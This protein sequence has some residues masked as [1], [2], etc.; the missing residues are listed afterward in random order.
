VHAGVV[1]FQLRRSFGRIFDLPPEVEL[2]G[3]SLSGDDI[4][5]LGRTVGHEPEPVLQSL[6]DDDAR[7][8]A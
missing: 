4:G 6:A 7:K 3:D 1:Q 8:C 2:R 5:P